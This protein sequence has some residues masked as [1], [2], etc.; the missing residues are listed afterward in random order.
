M[1]EYGSNK[2]VCFVSV[3]VVIP[4]PSRTQDS[5]CI[6]NSGFALVAEVAFL[7]FLFV[8]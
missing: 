1:L 6:H 3:L 4:L 5:L 7:V 8:T 2:N